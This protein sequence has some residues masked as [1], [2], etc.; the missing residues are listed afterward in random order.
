[1]LELKHIHIKETIYT[2]KVT[3]H[4]L[5]VETE[6]TAFKTAVVELLNGQ[7]EFTDGPISYHEQLVEADQ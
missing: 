2:D 1:M 7:V 3:V 5:I 6:V 4:C